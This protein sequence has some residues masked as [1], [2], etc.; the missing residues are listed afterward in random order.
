MRARLLL[1]VFLAGCAGSRYRGPALLAGAGA[2]FAGG[3][4]V[5]F[6]V[7]DR[8]DNHAAETVGV[9]SLGLGLGAIFAAGV[10][11]AVRSTCEVDSDCPETESCQRLYTTA[12][13]YGYCYPR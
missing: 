5:S 2:L 10:W 7:G 9:I 13:P 4:S 1:L 8:D 12:G 11:A 3:G 6:G